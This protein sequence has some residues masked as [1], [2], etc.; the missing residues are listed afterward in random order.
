MRGSAEPRPGRLRA[1]RS[2]IPRSEERVLPAARRASDP[3][4]AEHWARY[5]FVASLARGRVADIGC[6][7]GYGAREI[8]RQPA[9]REVLACDRSG[10][11]LAWG[12]RYYPD[13]RIVWREV[14]LERPRWERGLGRFDT[15]VAFEILEHLGDDRP[16]LEGM[17]RALAAAGT[18]W[19][20][21]PLGR[22][23]GIAVSDPFH[24]HQL[25]RQ[26][27]LELLG[28]GWR[29]EAYGQ[30]GEW[31]E[32]WEA[33]RRYRTILLRGVRRS[34]RGRDRPGDERE[35]RWR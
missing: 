28:A 24:V 15:I 35:G 32:P 33:G 19:L 30:Q 1:A 25:R 34:D 23:R 11:A 22:G 17:E 21:T 26:E 29:T 3:M 9:V 27:A 2:T 6:G 5:R 18:I 20:S 4:L 31:I 14:D 13:P 12:A 10:E 8:A 7:C 16:L